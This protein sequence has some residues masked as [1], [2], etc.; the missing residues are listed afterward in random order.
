VFIALTTVQW[1]T[2]PLTN[3]RTLGGVAAALPVGSWPCGDLL[4]P[5][6]CDRRRSKPGI[7]SVSRTSP[8]LIGF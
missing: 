4:C 7:P 6:W 2:Y 3:H 1:G 5:D 8:A